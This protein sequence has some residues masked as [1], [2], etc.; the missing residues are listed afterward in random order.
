MYSIE[1]A[2]FE[3]SDTDNSD[4]YPNIKW[5]PLRSELNDE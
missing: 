2:N 3:M 4:L 1:N 5:L